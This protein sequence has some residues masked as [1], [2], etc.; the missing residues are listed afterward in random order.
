MSPEGLDLDWT[1]DAALGGRLRL[2][3]PRRGHRFGHDAVLLAAAT[4]A[5]AGDRVV[6]LG[7]GVGTGGLALAWRVSGTMVT[8]VEI[9]PRLAALAQ[10]NAH[11]NGFQDRVRA[12]ALDVTAPAQTFAAQ[13]LAPGRASRVLMNPPY[14]HPLRH[15]AS[16]EEGRSAAHVGSAEMLA[17]WCRVAARLLAPGG[18]LALIWRAEA[19]GEVLAALEGRFGAVAVRPVHPRPDAAAIRILVSAETASRAPLKLLP[20]LI[21]NDISGRATREAE[22]ILREGGPLPMK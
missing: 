16:P 11:L 1:E 9:D 15:N 22:A 18:T 8:L 10:E 14:N 6:E 5:R 2:R 19:I 21:L 7:A 12:L 13:G 17:V 4:P 20:G 3:Q